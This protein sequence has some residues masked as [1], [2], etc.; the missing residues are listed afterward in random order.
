ML[1][2]SFIVFLLFITNLEGQSP[3]TQKDWFE[4]GQ[5]FLKKKK[6][7]IA[8][9]QYIIAEKSGSDTEI[10]KLARLKIDSILP[11]AQKKIIKKMKGDWKLKEF[12]GNF[13]HLKFSQY[14]KI[15]DR[16]I[17][18]YKKNSL[19]KKVVLRREQIRFL[20]YD[21]LK[22]RFSIRKIVFKNT[23]IWEFW[24]SHK[25]L[26]KKLYPKIDTDSLGRGQSRVNTIIINVK[27][28][29]KAI[30]IENSTFYVK[31]KKFFF[32]WSL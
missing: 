7:E 9:T 23:E 1:R 5:K 3:K 2:L 22:K 15:S 14:I 19:G 11:L 21:S 17:V 12:H 28:R 18:F 8:V 16:E 26:K 6:F 13:H 29:K 24:L 32:I 30:K 25:K 10:K 20:P 4:S 27:E 31:K